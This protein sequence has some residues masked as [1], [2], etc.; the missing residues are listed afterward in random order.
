[1]TRFGL[2]FRLYEAAAERGEWLACVRLARMYAHGRGIK[3]DERSAFKWYETAMS[4]ADSI[5]PCP[6]LTEAVEY[7]RSHSA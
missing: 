3:V 2:A 1:M 5:T 6:E 4:E 7:V